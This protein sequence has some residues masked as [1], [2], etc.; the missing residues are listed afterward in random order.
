MEVLLRKGTRILG[1]RIL[2]KGK[3]D[4]GSVTLLATTSSPLR[5]EKPEMQ[6]DC[7]T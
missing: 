4:A 5:A 6:R 3:L 2:R 7:I 1:D